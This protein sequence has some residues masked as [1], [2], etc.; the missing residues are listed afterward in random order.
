MVFGVTSNNSAETIY[1]TF[2]SI[3]GKSCSRAVVIVSG[4]N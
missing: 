3:L 4:F 1:L 2:T